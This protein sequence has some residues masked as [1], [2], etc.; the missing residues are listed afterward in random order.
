MYDGRKL[1]R[2]VGEDIF[3]HQGVKDK[4]GVAC[5]EEVALSWVEGFEVVGTAFKV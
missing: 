1:V 5:E 4:G 3:I 2:R